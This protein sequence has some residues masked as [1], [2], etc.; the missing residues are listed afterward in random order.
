MK[1]SIYFIQSIVLIEVSSKTLS[2]ARGILGN[3]N[4]FNGLGW[5]SY[6]SSTMILHLNERALG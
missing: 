4:E 1:V 2:H 5:E 3:I 6:R